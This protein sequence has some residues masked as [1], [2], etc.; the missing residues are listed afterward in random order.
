MNLIFVI[1]REFF[2]DLDKEKIFLFLVV[3]FFGTGAWTQGLTLSRQAFYHSSHSASGTGIWTQGSALAK[4]RH[5]MT[6]AMPL[7]LFAQAILD[8]D[9]PT[10][11][12]L[13]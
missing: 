11:H 4:G 13:L 8:S 3:L 1:I 2:V 6:W 12:F 7:A 10:L 9:H 5:S